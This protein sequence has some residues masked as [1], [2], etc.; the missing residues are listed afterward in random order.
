M[1]IRQLCLA[2]LKCTGPVVESGTEVFTLVGVHGSEL[3]LACSKL[4]IC[5]DTILQRCN[6]T[7]ECVGEAYFQ[8]SAPPNK[9]LPLSYAPR[10]RSYKCMACVE[11]PSTLT[12]VPSLALSAVLYIRPDRR[13]YGERGVGIASV[14]IYTQKN[15]ARGLFH[16]SK[17]EDPRILST[18]WHALL[19]A[20]I[21]SPSELCS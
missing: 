3:E 15:T 11:S 1:V 8:H 14:K 7:N 4:Q 13:I 5:V 21:A 12:R 6:S 9:T 20:S 10:T 19:S 16:L 17:C 18:V 2:S